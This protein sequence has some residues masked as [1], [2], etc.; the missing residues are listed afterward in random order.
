MI[1]LS[2][3]FFLIASAV[4]PV[5]AEPPPQ[6]DIVETAVAAGSFQ[7]LVTALK[8]AELVDTLK[9]DGPFTVFAPT[10]AAFA[11]LPPETVAELLKPESRERLQAILTYHVVPGRLEAADLLAH[12]SPTSLNGARIPVSFRNGRVGIQKA[13][14][15]AP[16]WPPSRP[17]GCGAR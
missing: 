2:L 11:K 4:R 15:L 17:R 9:S 12:S 10:D 6:R 1:R 13:S 7:V 8:T 14:L 5:A 16:C 3:L